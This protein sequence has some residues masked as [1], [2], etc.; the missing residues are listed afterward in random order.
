MVELLGYLQ[1]RWAVLDH[2][3]GFVSENVIDDSSEAIE[4]SFGDP[5]Y[6][7]STLWNSVGTMMTQIE[8]WERHAS[9]ECP[10]S[11]TICSRPFMID[12]DP[13]NEGGYDYY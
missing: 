1:I 4:P 6:C 9:G 7:C 10:S 12:R 11:I 2:S 5:H 13:G 3:D 8:T